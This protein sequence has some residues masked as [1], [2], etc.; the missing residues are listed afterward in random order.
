MYKGSKRKGMK[1]EHVRQFFK[2]FGNGPI[3][4]VLFYF[5]CIKVKGNRRLHHKNCSLRF[6]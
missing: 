5:G 2:K 3:N 4:D 6:L 1:E